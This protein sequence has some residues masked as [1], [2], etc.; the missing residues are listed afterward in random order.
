MVFMS[1]P[2]GYE[3]S[4]KE[5]PRMTASAPLV[6]C[7]SHYTTPS[8]LKIGMKSLDY[9]RYELI[10]IFFKSHCISN[11]KSPQFISF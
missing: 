2:Q 7:F 6:R 8:L 4:D 3:V 10:E 11:L 1:L 9:H 5:T